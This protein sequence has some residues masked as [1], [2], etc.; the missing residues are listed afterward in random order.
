MN[1]GSGNPDYQPHLAKLDQTG[2][3][4]WETA[5]PTGGNGF[6]SI[7]CV[8]S[9]K[10]GGFF[11][12]GRYYRYVDATHEN[13]CWIGIYNSQ[14]SETKKIL[15][16]G[17]LDLYSALQTSD[18]GFVGVGCGAKAVDGTRFIKLSANGTVQFDKS[19]QSYLCIE[20]TAS[21]P[22]ESH[23]LVQLTENGKTYYFIPGKAG[24]IKLDEN[25]T[26]V[27]KSENGCS[28]VY[29]LTATMDGGVIS[30]GQDFG[31]SGEPHNNICL[32]KLSKDGSKIWIKKYPEFT[33]TQ[34]KN[35]SSCMAVRETKDGGLI[36]TGYHDADWNSETLSSSLIL[37]KT[38][39]DGNVK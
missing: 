26:V 39:K 14:G 1:I 4:M 23:S 21:V 8:R 19:V 15:F 6:N 16:Y 18:A 31:A 30:C 33:K 34:S 10:S 5:F 29:S 28:W 9:M 36:V 37:M 38:D 20:S 27:T 7:N 11:V 17:D 2:K 3:L 22:I 12:T 24:F 32:A 35:D 13:D 25:G